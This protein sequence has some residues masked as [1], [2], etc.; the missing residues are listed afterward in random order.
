MRTILFVIALSA[1]VSCISLSKEVDISGTYRSEG[2]YENIIEITR[3]EDNRYTAQV[4][5]GRS[6][7]GSLHGTVLEFRIFDETRC[8]RF[9][10][11]YGYFLVGADNER[12]EKVEK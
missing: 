7:T 3:I 9:S 10:D 4:L 6:Y 5:G 12:D 8:F 2:M 1:A 11:D